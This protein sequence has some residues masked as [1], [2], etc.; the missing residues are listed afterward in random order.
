MN[1][2]IKGQRL[3]QEQLDAIVP[4]MNRSMWGEVSQSELEA[5]ALKAMEAAGCPLVPE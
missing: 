3:T 1:I 2:M 5:E 4:I